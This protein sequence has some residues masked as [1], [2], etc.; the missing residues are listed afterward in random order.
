MEGGTVTTRSPSLR[1]TLDS[2]TVPIVVKV[3]H[4]VP[5]MWRPW[6]H[7]IVVGAEGGLG[8]IKLCAVFLQTI[9]D[10]KHV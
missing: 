1:L 8:L 3:G 7:Q 4:G 9:Q 10:G 2:E 5:Q 6:H